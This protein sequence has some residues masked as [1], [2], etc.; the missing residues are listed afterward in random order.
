MDK[1]SVGPFLYVLALERYY[2]LIVLLSM[3]AMNMKCPW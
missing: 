3:H 1:F 2:E